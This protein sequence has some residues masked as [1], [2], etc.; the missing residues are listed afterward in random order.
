[1]VKWLRRDI[2]NSETSQR[3]DT[4]V[5]VAIAMAVLGLVLAATM[6]IINRSLLS[7]M[8]A[9][10]RTS[11][12]G[13]VN[14]QVEM[15]R[16]VFDTQGGVN[17]TVAREIIEHTGTADVSD[18]GCSAGSSAFYLTT[19]T[20]SS[21]DI[22][23]IQRNT[24]TANA[25]VADTVYGAPHAVDN[26]GIWIEGTKHLTDVSSGVPGYIDF[27]VRA[28]WSPYASNEVGQGRLESIVRVYLSEEDS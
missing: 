24:Y 9:V 23:P 13:E 19:R 21:D 17:K 16:Y 22:T 26:G 4:L 28:C 10:E 8:N 5:E 27:Y 20:I 11:A 12:R 3:G 15:L 18:D 25:L 14:S 2:N 7:V 6:T 1:M